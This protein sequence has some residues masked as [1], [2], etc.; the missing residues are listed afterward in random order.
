MPL[1]LMYITNA[2]AVARL[3]MAAGVD[4]LFVDMEYIFKSDRQRGRDTVQNHHT[5]ADVRRMRRCID[6][7]GGATEL[8]VRC[9]PIHEATALYASSRAEVDAVVAAGADILML[10]YFKT[11]WEARHFL[12]LVGGRARTMLLIETPE[13]VE[14][15]DDILA[16]P[17]I[18]EVY[19]GL[20]DLS[21]GYG[22]HFLFELLADGT[23]EALCRRFLAA[24]LPY[25]FGGVASIGR[26]ILPAEYIIAEH[27]R[28]GSTSSILSRSF[29]NA[30]AYPDARALAPVFHAELA[31]LR[32]EEAF[33]ARQAPAFFAANAARV[34][35]IVADAVE[36]FYRVPT[37]AREAAL[38]AACGS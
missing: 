21:I 4:R 26:G 14:A 35:G 27:Y 9:N 29:C 3:A 33:C 23:V 5:V 24:G 22:L 28:L 7:A 15:L 13:A 30:A 19:V 34:Q 10:P 2:P 12:E 11:V 31:R 6:A 1:K 37:P 38:S 25:G 32:A 20:N 17:G 36:D 16:L 18:D 8:L